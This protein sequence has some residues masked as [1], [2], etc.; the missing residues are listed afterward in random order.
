YV[1]NFQGQHPMHSHARD[2]MYFVLEGKVTIRFKSAPA[3]VL[4]KGDCLTVPAYMTHSSESA[5]GA[6]VLMIKP[7]DM[8]PDPKDLE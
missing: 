6:L 7:R 8:F 3:E 1:M 5:E 4:R 2:E